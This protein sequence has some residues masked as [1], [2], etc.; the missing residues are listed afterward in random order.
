MP[1]A[2]ATAASV[3]TAHDA[4]RFHAHHP[5]PRIAPCCAQDQPTSYK[6]KACRSFAR[7][8]RCPYGPRCRFMHGDVR[9]AQHLAVMRLADERP[10]PG[11]TAGGSDAPLAPGPAAASMAPAAASPAAAM[12][13]ADFPPVSS[14]AAGIGG[15]GLAAIGGGI[16][17]GAAPCDLSAAL[18]NRRSSSS[19]EAELPLP[20]PPPMAT[21]LKAMAQMSMAPAAAAAHHAVLLPYAQLPHADAHKQPLPSVAAG[22]WGA[23]PLRPFASSVHKSATSAPFSASLAGQPLPTGGFGPAGSP[24]RTSPSIQVP[25]A[26]SSPSG[27]SLLPSPSSSRLPSTLPSTLPS[28]ALLPLPVPLSSPPASLPLLPPAFIPAAGGLPSPQLAHTA[29][30]IHGLPPQPVAATNLLAQLSAGAS[31][32]GHQHGSSAGLCGG[33]SSGSAVAG[34]LVAS[35]SPR[36][37]SSLS[38]ALTPTGAGLQTAN[39]SID[40]FGAALQASSMFGSLPGLG[41]P[42]SAA[43]EAL[44]TST[45]TAFTRSNIAKQLSV[46]FDENGGSSAQNLQLLADGVD[47]M[48]LGGT[49]EVAPPLGWETKLGELPTSAKVW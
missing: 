12:R 45:A 26:N 3:A 11:G 43:D 46:L 35:S 13:L 36:I 49:S 21:S 23:P 37:G 19:S 5:P 9:E 20:H 15:G 4:H 10:F 34:G 33:S 8:G 48:D 39:V 2:R 28:P 29:S 25:F 44:P 22:G 47:G 31:G 17:G 32:P 18:T 41:E 14:A 16:G 7:T 24:M 6:T 1:G 38:A 42:P 27:S 40:G 30:S